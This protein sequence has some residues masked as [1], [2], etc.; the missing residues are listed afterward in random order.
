MGEALIVT[1]LLGGFI[2]VLSGALWI[3]GLATGG[4]GDGSGD[5]RTDT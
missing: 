1:G 5:D 4:P 3:I 2:A